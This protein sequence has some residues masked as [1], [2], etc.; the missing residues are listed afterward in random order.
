MAQILRFCKIMTNSLR[1][2]VCNSSISRSLLS[3]VHIPLLCD[4]RNKTF[5]INKTA[6]ELWKGVT[7]VSNAGRKRGRAKGLARKRDLNKGQI[8]GVG[9]T[10][11]LFPGLNAPIFRGREMLRQQ[12]L[13]VDPEREEK[14][15]KFRQSQSKPKRI[16]VSPL[17]RGWTSAGM[18]GRRMGPPDPVGDDTFDGFESW[19][20]E[21]KIVTHM[22][23]NM[24]RKSRISIFVVTG[25]GNGLAG[26]AMRKAPISKTAIRNAKNRA[27]QKL[28]YIP[29]Y[30][31]HTVL[32]D[33]FT[34]FGKT[35]IFVKKMHEG[36]GLIC[37][38]A[39]KACCE[40]I[41]IKDMYAKVEGSTNLQHIIKAFFIG[42]LRQKS[43]QQLA[44]EKRLHLVEFRAEN[45]NYPEVVASP[46]VVRRPEE[47]PSNEVLDFTQY[48]MDGKIV[49]Q[50]K[51]QEPFYVKLP[52]YQIHLKKQERLRHFDDTRIRLM[53]EH[54][55][56]RSFLTKQYPEAQIRRLKRE[57][58]EES[59]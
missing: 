12:K 42:L 35:K 13:P 52:S 58:T 28:M 6:D 32:H 14:L 25:N 49:L 48:V 4:A 56:L 22:T 57:K 17:E 40:A 24:G 2:D 37:H 10:P 36:Y 18:G 27:G 29:R 41:G 3:K 23:G 54:G 9:K 38:R 59:E 43:H 1:N 11:I 16:K 47:V 39:I 55:R 15:I 26:F 30:K 5:F 20:L 33:F 7:S 53:S 19:I 8:I 46:S 31:E 34:Q 50:K 21:S 51:K 44:D 45:G